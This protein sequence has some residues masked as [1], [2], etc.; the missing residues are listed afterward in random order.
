VV[1][2]VAKMAGAVVAMSHLV[3]LLLVAN[4][5]AII[6]AVLRCAIG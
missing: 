3:G 5:A 4:I 6:T 2:G 1:V